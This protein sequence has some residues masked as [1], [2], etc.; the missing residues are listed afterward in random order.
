MKEVNKK[1]SRYRCVSKKGLNTTL[2]EEELNVK[3]WIAEC[4]KKSAPVSTKSL[5]CCV[6][7]I[8]ET[9]KEKSLKFKIRWAYSS[10]KSH[11]F[12]IRRISHRIQFIPREHT[13]IKTNL[14]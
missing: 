13:E 4:R 1:E 12:S 11:G 14:L 3:N 10:Q 6:G 2:S 7:N 8:N 9:L 5:V